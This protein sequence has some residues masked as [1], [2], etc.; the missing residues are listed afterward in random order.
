MSE[1]IQESLLY[2]G[3]SDHTEDSTMYIHKLRK[4]L[5]DLDRKEI[6][7]HGGKFLQRN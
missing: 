2:K 1:R 5:Y 3:S 7:K 6:K 4:S